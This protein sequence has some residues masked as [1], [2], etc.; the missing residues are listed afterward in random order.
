M[1]EDKL[2]ARVYCFLILKYDVDN[3]RV[4]KQTDKIGVTLDGGGLAWLGSV[5]YTLFCNK[6]LVRA[7][8]QVYQTDL[9]PGGLSARRLH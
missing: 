7:P 4:V 3:I 9:N 8:E 2:K 5:T 6:L 1:R